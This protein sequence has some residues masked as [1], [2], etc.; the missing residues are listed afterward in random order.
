MMAPTCSVGN[1]KACSL[2]VQGKCNL[3]GSAPGWPQFSPFLL[4]DVE[5]TWPFVFS[6]AH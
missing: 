4:K 1:R 6:A 5:S 2:G 3:E